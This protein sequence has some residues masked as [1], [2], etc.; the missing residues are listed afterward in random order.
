[1]TGTEQRYAVYVRAYPY[2]PFVRM[3]NIVNKVGPA[4]ARAARC[5]DAEVRAWPSHRLVAVTTSRGIQT[6]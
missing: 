2:C 4:L 6:V 5:A 3:G 1:M